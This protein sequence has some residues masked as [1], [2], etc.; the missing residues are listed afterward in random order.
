MGCFESLFA[1]LFLFV[2]WL[3]GWLVGWLVVLLIMQERVAGAQDLPSNASLVSSRSPC[4]R[5]VP[6]VSIPFIRIGINHQ[7]EPRISNHGLKY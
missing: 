3:V 2:C 4:S 1:C 6:K 5:P 7:H